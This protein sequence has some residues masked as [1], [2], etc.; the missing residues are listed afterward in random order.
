MRGVGGDG[1]AGEGFEDAFFDGGDVVAGDG[2]A[3]DFVAEFEASA[4]LAG[5]N[6]ECDA[7]VLAVAAGLF[8]VEVFGLADGGDGFA[9]GDAAV[10]DVNFDFEFAEEL[11]GGELDMGFA[12]AGE[13]HF[14]VVAVA[15]DAE[16]GVFFDEACEAGAE[17]VDVG[18]GAWFDGGGED[19]GGHVGRGDDQV[20]AGFAEGVEGGG[21]GEFGDDA[22]VADGHFGGGLEVFAE[23]VGEAGE[24]LVV[25]FAG[26]FEVG[27][28]AHGA[29]GDAQVGEAADEFVGGGF[30]DE[31]G[32]I[33]G[34]VGFDAVGEGWGFEGVGEGGFDQ[35]EERPDADGGGGAGGQ[36]GD[37]GAGLD[38]RL[39]AGGEV[40]VGQF[41]VFEVGHHEVF[42]DFDDSLDQSVAGVG[43]G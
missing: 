27:V 2:A 33:A 26:V 4:A 11:S 37:E 3:D 34:G 8:F 31:G 24:A 9:V 30:E 36:D 15:L 7:G 43:G 1:A 19:G 29:G 12:E 38:G 42:I 32:G 40:V 25:A 39:E 20:G 16:G 21:A 17:F 5:F 18:F 13:D 35:A 22:E 6:A 10:A 23:G 28:S 14:A 41:F